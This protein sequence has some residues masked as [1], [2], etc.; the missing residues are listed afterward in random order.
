MSSE[1]YVL[2]QSYRQELLIGQR[3][4]SLTCK[5]MARATMIAEWGRMSMSG[6]GL[7]YGGSTLN[8]HRG[9]EP[10]MSDDEFIRIND[11]VESLPLLNNAVIK[12]LYKFQN[13][14]RDCAAKMGMSKTSIE[15]HHEQ[16]LSMLYGKLCSR[17]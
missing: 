5:Q 10:P 9:A 12:H 15:R 11:A 6:L 8:L 3:P 13:S 4:V 16:A 2:A 14:I 7:G 1:D 17:A